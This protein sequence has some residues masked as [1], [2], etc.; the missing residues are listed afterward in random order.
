[1]QR[2]ATGTES[3]NGLRS[4]V[5]L[6][7]PLNDALLRFSQFESAFAFDEVENICSFEAVLVVEDIG[8]IRSE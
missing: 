3:T 4:V 2:Y 8:V 7:R 1:V 6:Q 5:R